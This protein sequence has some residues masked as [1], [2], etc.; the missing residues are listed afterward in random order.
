M[1]EDKASTN[2]PTTEEVRQQWNRLTPFYIT[3]AQNNAP[4]GISLLNLLKAE[5]AD[6]IIETGVGAG[7]FFP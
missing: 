5:A 1:A 2:Q 4:F 6:S 3:I 7:N